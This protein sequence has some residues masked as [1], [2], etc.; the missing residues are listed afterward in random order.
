MDSVAA[1]LPARLE[2]FTATL[3]DRLRFCSGPALARKTITVHNFLC[4]VQ[5][6][7]NNRLATRSEYVR[8]NRPQ[9]PLASCPAQLLLIIA[10][11]L[12]LED[13]F[14]FAQVNQTIRAVLISRE[15]LWNR[16]ALRLLANPSDLASLQIAGSMLKLSPR[17][18]IHLRISSPIHEGDS[19]H[20]QFLACHMPR[21]ATLDLEFWSGYGFSN[22]TQSEMRRGPLQTEWRTLCHALS[23]PAPM[24]NTLILV[25][26]TTLFRSRSSRNRV[27]LPADILGGVDG[28]LRTFALTNV[29]LEQKTTY[30]ALRNLVN[31]SYSAT[32]RRELRGSHLHHLLYIM[33]QLETLRLN[34][35]AYV[36]SISPVPKLIRRRSLRRVILEGFATGCT[37]L[38]YFFQDITSVQIETTRDIGAELYLLWPTPDLHVILG[39]DRLAVRGEWTCSETGRSR[40]IA[41]ITSALVSRASRGLD[42]AGLLSAATSGSIRPALRVVTLTVDESQWR[43]T[44]ILQPYVNVHTLR[45]VL[46]ACCEHLRFHSPPGIFSTGALVQHQLSFLRT[47]AIYSGTSHVKQRLKRFRQVSPTLYASF[48]RPLGFGCGCGSSG[49]TSISLID[50]AD[51]VNSLIPI[52]GRL[53]QLVLSGIDHIAD[54]YNPEF[55]LFR[56]S[57]RVGRIEA[58]THVPDQI[59]KSCK[60]STELDSSDLPEFLQPVRDAFQDY[61]L[62]RY[63]SA[64][65]FLYAMI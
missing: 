30:P 51:F 21:V 3:I 49:V 65:D 11:A 2:T 38:A 47:V 7:I 56:L 28:L 50:L 18:P 41:L 14:S 5:G 27:Y 59:V 39:S 52:P 62:R 57:Q 58:L 36:T 42:A 25:I 9:S 4:T 20:V 13:R 24:L 45:I 54:V 31:F 37:L 1:P 44:L 26:R 61:Y 55:G 8:L 15:E 63:D 17:Q 10:Q 43:D 22:P 23:E 33:P 35:D 29:R 48:M 19:E 60:S 6:T 53:P 40:E 32:G 12:E 64:V 16:V 46:C 34:F